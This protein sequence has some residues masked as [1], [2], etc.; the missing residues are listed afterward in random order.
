MLDWYYEVA[1]VRGPV[2]KTTSAERNGER[3]C[4]WETLACVAIIASLSCEAKAA[5]RMEAVVVNYPSRYSD[6]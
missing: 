2:R 6:K 4:V 3:S 5:L 1:Q